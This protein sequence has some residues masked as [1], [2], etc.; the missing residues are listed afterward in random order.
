MKKITKYVLISFLVIGVLFSAAYFAKTNSKSSITYKTEKLFKTTIEKETVVTGKVIPEDEVEV[1]PQI[2]GIIDRILVEEGDKVAAG[3]LIARIKVVPNEQSLNTAEGF[4]KKAQIALNT[5]QKEYNRNRELYEKGI[6]SNV[7]FTAFE[8]QYNQA[9]QDVVNAQNDLKIIKE[10]SVGGSSAANTNIRATVAG[11]VLEIV[12]KEGDQVINPN[13]FNAGTT[14]AAIADL[15]KMIFEGKVDEAEVAS[16][17]VGAPLKVSLGAIEDQELDAKLTFIAPKGTEEQGSVQ[18][19]IEADME[20][21]DSIFVRAGY[22]AN[23]SLV[24]D[25]KEDVLALREAL[26]QF[27]RKTQDPYVEVMIG[28]QKFERREVKLGISDGVN[29]EILEGVAQ[30]D[31]VKV[32]NRTEEKEDD[33]NNNSEDDA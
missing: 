19:K 23:A 32:W 33:N 3:D 11:T 2:S 7:E 18:F 16:L 29:V 8:L 22:S 31:E 21:N 25:K 20:L 24:L 17:R 12:V 5:Q 4:L 9:K 15:G 30:E 6:I 14:I 1:K 27:D 26:I 13:S 10:G 28:D